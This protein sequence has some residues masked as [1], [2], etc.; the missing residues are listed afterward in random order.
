GGSERAKAND[1]FELPDAES[2]IYAALLKERKAPRLATPHG[3]QLARLYEDEALLVINKPAEVPVHRGEGGFT[4]RD[5]LEDALAR[6]YPGSA[7][8][9]PARGTAFQAV[10]EHGQDAR[11]TNEGRQD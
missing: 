3:R 7:G 9:Q 2:A 10:N 5:T 4:R 6:V 11:A 1:V 8:F